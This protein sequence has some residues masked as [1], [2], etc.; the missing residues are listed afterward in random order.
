MGGRRMGRSWFPIGRRWM[1]SGDVVSE[2]VTVVVVLVAPCA[3]AKS[4]FEAAN[5]VHVFE[6]VVFCGLAE[7]VQFHRHAKR[8]RV[9]LE[10]RK[11]TTGTT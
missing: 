9:G 11:R 8:Q 4:E 1:K 5:R 6:D 10:T 2:A 3:T 7:K